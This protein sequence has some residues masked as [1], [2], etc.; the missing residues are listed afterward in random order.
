MIR[1]L[2]DASRNRSFKSK[3][4]ILRTHFLPRK[5]VRTVKCAGF[6]C[7]GAEERN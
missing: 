4:A 3:M 7:A 5:I 1:R 2:K 6:L